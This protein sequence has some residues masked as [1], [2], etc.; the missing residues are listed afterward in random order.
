MHV[1]TSIFSQ[2][3]ALVSGA[4]LKQRWPLLAT[5]GHIMMLL[6]AIWIHMI[7]VS[8]M[9]PSGFIK[10]NMNTIKNPSSIHGWPC[11]SLKTDDHHGHRMAIPRTSVTAP[12]FGACRRTPPT[13]GPWSCAGHASW[14]PKRAPCGSSPTEWGYAVVR[15]RAK[16][17]GVFIFPRKKWGEELLRPS[18]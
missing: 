10:K 8:P 16:Q 1:S 3:P 15:E 13:A 14:E 11:E 12:A 7:V 4:T 2:F 5:I 6:L 9:N 18:I 17:L